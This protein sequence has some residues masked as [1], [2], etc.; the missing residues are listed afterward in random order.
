MPVSMAG[1]GSRPAA[2]LAEKLW[3][4][5]RGVDIS[6]DPVACAPALEPFQSRALLSQTC[7]ESL[8]VCWTSARDLSELGVCPRGPAACAIPGP[9]LQRRGV[10]NSSVQQVPSS[11]QAAALN[12]ADRLARQVEHSSV[13]ST[14]TTN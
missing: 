7:V 4:D 8:P 6:C 2:Q 13:S 5:L 14:R 10:D 11:T 1:S 9:H 3:G 12:R